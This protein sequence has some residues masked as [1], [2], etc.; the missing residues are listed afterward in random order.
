MMF[1]LGTWLDT[2]AYHSS[3]LATVSVILSAFNII[4]FV[5]TESL[6]VQKRLDCAVRMASPPNIHKSVQ[7]LYISDDSRW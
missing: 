1:M 3:I 5:M 2:W 7:E 6:F 4:V